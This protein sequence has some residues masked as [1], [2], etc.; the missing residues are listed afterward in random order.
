MCTRV[1]D[2]R[3]YV[4]GRRL[5]ACINTR[6]FKGLDSREIT[7]LPEIKKVIYMARHFNHRL[8]YTACSSQDAFPYNERPSQLLTKEKG[9]DESFQVRF[10]LPFLPTRLTAP[11]SPRMQFPRSPLGTPGTMT[12]FCVLNTEKNEQKNESRCLRKRD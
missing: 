5:Y 7:P 12:L 8:K 10:D 9:R 2:D 1:S 3:K 4:Y 11:G 6:K